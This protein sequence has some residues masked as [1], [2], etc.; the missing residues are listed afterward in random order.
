MQMLKYKDGK[1][2]MYNKKMMI[3][4]VFA[5][6]ICIIALV[7]VFLVSPENDITSSNNTEVSQN[8]LKNKS[9]ETI[10]YDKKNNNLSVS[11]ILSENELNNILYSSI[12]NNMKIT[13]M[14]TN[15]N[16]NNIQIYIDTYFL[17]VISTQYE[18]EF[19]PS[20]RND[21]LVLYLR[22]AKI[23]KVPLSKSYILKKLNKIDSKYI[24]V[25]IK[26]NC[27]SINSKFIEPFKISSFNIEN[28]KIRISMNYSVKSLI[29]L[30]KLL[31]NNVSSNI[32]N[33]IK[34]IIGNNL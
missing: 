10:E 7:T 9:P 5:I 32:K 26:N 19:I 12:K 31:I 34:K 25:N 20:I 1:F 22:S 3:Y 6:I 18:L 29:D 11:I 24:L 15:I 4:S 28:G 14:E 2:I 8:F 17:N 21:A 23:G 33:Y 27:I 16:Y 30:S 13:K